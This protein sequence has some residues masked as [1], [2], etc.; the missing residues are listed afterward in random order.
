M[1]NKKIH[2]P[3]SS[4]SQLINVISILIIINQYQQSEKN[5]VRWALFGD[6]YFYGRDLVTPTNDWH[7]KVIDV[8][9]STAINI[10][11]G[12]IS[13]RMLQYVRLKSR[14]N[15][16]RYIFSVLNGLIKTQ[17]KREKRTGVLI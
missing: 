16:D 7:F 8:G 13:K 2:F 1:S 12:N 10:Y 17:F 11:N 9:D 14:N 4:Q 15:G 5:A 6:L 3:Y